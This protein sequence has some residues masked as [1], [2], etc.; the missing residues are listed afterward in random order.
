[1]KHDWTSHPDTVKN[2]SV[3]KLLWFYRQAFRQGVKTGR[4]KIPWV[5]Q[6][7]F[8]DVVKKHGA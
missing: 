1:M 2:K 5:W 7:I 3:V 6:P 4:A 8:V